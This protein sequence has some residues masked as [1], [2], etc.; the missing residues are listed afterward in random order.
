MYYEDTDFEV[1]DRAAELAQRRGVKPAQ[2]AL[3]WMLHRPGTTAP[4]IGASKMQH[5]DDAVAAVDLKL[6]A[7]EMKHLEA[8]YRPHPILGH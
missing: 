6:D 4:I 1:A 7:D 5:L 8:P 2:I 3:A